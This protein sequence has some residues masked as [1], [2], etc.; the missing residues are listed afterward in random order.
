MIAILNN[1]A[2]GLVAIQSVL[3]NCSRINIANSYLI[4]PLMFDKQI[5]GYLKRK[6]TKLIS[7]QEVVT[8]KSDY[9]VGFNDKYFDSLLVT[10]NSIA[11]GI[12]LGLLRKEGKYLDHIEQ[13]PYIAG[14]MGKKVDEILLASKN[15]SVMLSEQ[16]DSVYSL[17]RVEI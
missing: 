3:A 4:L 14:S 9:F 16:P 15:V 7:L 13:R 11:M 12:E 6:T 2:I 17:L 8:A 10:T 1:E 5:R